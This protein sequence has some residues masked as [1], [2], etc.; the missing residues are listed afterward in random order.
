MSR[1][2]LSHPKVALLALILLAGCARA[3]ILQVDDLAPR[4]ERTPESVRLLLDLP[5]NG[6]RTIAVIQSRPRSLFRDVESL[7]AEVRAEAARLG[8]DAVVLSLAS[9]GEPGGS[10]TS[11]DGRIVFVSGSREG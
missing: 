10:G 11:A 3:E 8:A 2:H 1:R 9:S 7:E 4:S 6:Y 5:E